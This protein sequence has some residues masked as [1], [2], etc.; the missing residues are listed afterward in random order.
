M[1]QGK[2]PKSI[3]LYIDWTFIKQGIAILPGQYELYIFNGYTAA[4]PG[5]IPCYILSI[6]GY[7]VI[8]HAYISY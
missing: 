7:H 2:V 5:D 3:V 4:G 1:G 6:Y 8:Y